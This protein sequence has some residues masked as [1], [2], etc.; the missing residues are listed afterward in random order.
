M[1][2]DSFFS[3]IFSYFCFF[4]AAYNE[5][6]HHDTTCDQL[7]VCQFVCQFIQYHSKYIYMYIHINNHDTSFS[8]FLTFKPCQG[9]LDLLK[10]I[11]TYPRDS[12]SSRRLRRKTRVISV[13]NLFANELITTMLPWQ[14]I[15]MTIMLLKKPVNYK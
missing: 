15:F 14:Y 11:R 1:G 3:L 8:S 4:V 5:Q 10:Y 13:K 6:C 9:K 2:V 7:S 12:I